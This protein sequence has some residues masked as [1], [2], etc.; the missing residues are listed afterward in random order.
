MTKDTHKHTPAHTDAAALC[1]CVRL[2][3][4]VYILS[5]N[6]FT[7]ELNENQIYIVEENKKGAPTHQFLNTALQA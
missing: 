5:I 2:K 6:C 1:V 7:S 3:G 4:I